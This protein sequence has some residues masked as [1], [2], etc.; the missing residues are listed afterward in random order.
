MES[1]M[2]LDKE[3]SAVDKVEEWAVSGVLLGTLA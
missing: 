1:D 3:L 2:E